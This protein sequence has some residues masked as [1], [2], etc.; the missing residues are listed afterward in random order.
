MKFT[1]LQHNQFHTHSFFLRLMDDE[2]HYLISLKDKRCKSYYRLKVFYCFDMAWKKLKIAGDLPYDD[3]ICEIADDVEKYIIEL[4]SELKKKFNTDDDAYISCYLCNVYYRIAKERFTDAITSFVNM[5]TVVYEA[6][7]RQKTPK[8]LKEIKEAFDN[9]TSKL[10]NED[11]R[12]R[13]MK[14]GYAVDESEFE[15][16]NR[17]MCKIIDNIK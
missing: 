16:I 2:A 14:D 11:E 8:H 13:M 1:Q 5:R 7:I 3:F 15:I 10:E 12:Q 6:Q 4:K 17:Y 9:Y